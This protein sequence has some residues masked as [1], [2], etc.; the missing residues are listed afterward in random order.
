MFGIG[1]TA[2]RLYC[3][4]VNF[5]CSKN[6]SSKESN[7]FPKFDEIDLKFIIPI[8]LSVFSLLCNLIHL[9]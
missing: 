3:F 5:K 6:E 1:N 9:K 7:H 2:A 8:D 4:Y